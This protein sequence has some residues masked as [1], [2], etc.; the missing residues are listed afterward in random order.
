MHAYN[1]AGE[2]INAVLAYE[3]VYEVEEP[4]ELPYI[5]INDDTNLINDNAITQMNNNPGDAIWYLLETGVQAFTPTTNELTGFAVY[6]VSPSTVE[7]MIIQMPNANILSWGNLEDSSSYTLL[8]GSQS[9]EPYSFVD[10]WNYVKFKTPLTV[11]PTETYYL[12]VRGYDSAGWAVAYMNK[13]DTNNV[14]PEGTNLDYAG[15]MYAFNYNNGIWSTKDSNLIGQFKLYFADPY[16]DN[17]EMID[18]EVVKLNQNK[19]IT[20]SFQVSSNTLSA[21]K[22][23]ITTIA[24][25][26]N[27]DKLE[28]IISSKK[29]GT[30]PIY[31]QDFALIDCETG[32]ID[33]PFDTPLNLEYGVTY[34]LILK[35]KSA[36]NFKINGLTDE[37]LPEY[38]MP[39]Y[40]QMGNKLNAVLAYGMIY[41]TYTVKFIDF[42]GTVLDT[43]VISAGGNATPPT[44]S[45]TGYD[46]VGWSQPYMNVT[47]DLEIE[48]VYT[49]ISY[50]IQFVMNGAD[51]P[52]NKLSANYNTT[53]TKPD[54]P[55]RKGYKFI[56]WYLDA[57]LTQKYNW[58]TPITE[59]VILYAG[60]KEAKSNVAIILVS[61]I[62]SIVVVGA[63]A[64]ITLVLIKKKKQI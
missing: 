8:E 10:G 12:V 55:T 14:E 19:S 3:M 54:D 11:N 5:T 46:F 13:Y 62:G 22:I 50:N 51:K 31:Q 44:V 60:W 40:D 15:L 21:I 41:K 53:A 59:D 36:T 30:D 49:I 61:V 20:Q 7:F 52:I 29:D 32:W 42:D 48:A 2:E 39:A 24:P 58:D 1:Q 64:G 26:T 43:Q 57:E 34:Y 45:R 63:V 28:V 35:S 18:N 33:I 38:Y 4:I 47:G 17:Q 25:F 6:S 56:G 37:N 27:N 23:H 9:L 16:K